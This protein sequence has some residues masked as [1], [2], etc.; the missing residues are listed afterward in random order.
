[1][2]NFKGQF[3]RIKGVSEK[4]RLPRLNKIR[5][6]KKAVSKKTG[7]EYPI[8]TPYFVVPPE[9]AKIYGEEPTEIDVMLPV[10]DEE[11]IFPQAYVWY[12]K[13]KGPKCIGNGEQAMRVNENGD[14]EPRECPC[15][16]LEEGECNRS[17]H[18]MVL[19]PRVNLG[20]IFQISTASYHTIVDINSGIDYIRALI[21]RV[22]M[23][24][25]KLKRIPRET[26]GSGRKETH[27]TLHLH[28]DANVEMINA[29]RENTRRVLMGQQFALPAPEQVNPEMDEGAVVEVVDEEDNEPKQNGFVPETKTDEFNGKKK[30]LEAC[31]TVE[32]LQE[33]WS[34]LIP[35]EKNLLVNLKNELK[36][37]LQ[38]E[39]EL[40]EEVFG[41]EPPE[42][43]IIGDEQSEG[44]TDSEAVVIVLRES[45]NEIPDK[46]D[47]VKDAMDKAIKVKQQADRERSDGKLNAND[48]SEISDMILKKMDKIKKSGKGKRRG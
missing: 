11:I 19:L 9:V 1:M 26:H 29:M 16:K 15:E 27:Y 17:A 18:L 10:E 36:R 43:P 2:Q 14:F 40:V 7:N 44:P 12:G 31:E 34:K 6:G 21:G 41:E 24:P 48:Y 28:L 42:E 8:E 30:A 4:R 32:A 39:R 38:P 45:L 13:S 47:D 22:A 37:K 25:C 5:L 46:P 3:T 20:G 35:K 33:V 23:V